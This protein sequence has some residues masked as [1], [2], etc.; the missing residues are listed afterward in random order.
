MKIFYKSISV[1]KE[2]LEK[3]SFSHEQLLFPKNVFEALKYAL[4]ESAALLPV[5][6]RKFQDWNVGLLQRFEEGDFQGEDRNVG[7][8]P[9]VGL[10]HGGEKEKNEGRVDVDIKSIPNSEALLE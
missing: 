6:A 5:E 1:P 8:T 2:V 4:E 10:D 7:I 9:E 3:N